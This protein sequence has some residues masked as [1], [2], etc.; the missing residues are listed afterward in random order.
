V[1]EAQNVTSVL[2][3]RI[4]KSIDGRRTNAPIASYSNYGPTDNP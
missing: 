2:A 3:S 4:T 1:M